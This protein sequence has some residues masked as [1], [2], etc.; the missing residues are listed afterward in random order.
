MNWFHYAVKYR[1][2]AFNIELISLP[3][4]R[5][6]TDIML[7]ISAITRF[8]KIQKGINLHALW[9]QW[10]HEKEIRWTKPQ[11]KIQTQTKEINLTH[12]EKEYR[13][14]VRF[15]YA[16]GLRTGEA[17]KAFDEHEQLCKD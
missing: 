8:I 12:I 11:P 1:H 5:K 7:G 4:T 3:N 9:L 13:D 6:K 17:I 16:T 10:L 15:L 2:I 14:F